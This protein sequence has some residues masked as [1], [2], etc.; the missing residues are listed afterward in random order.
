MRKYSTYSA[1]ISPN[2]GEDRLQKCS[3]NFIDEG[4]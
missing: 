2:A 4:F 1:D 3:F